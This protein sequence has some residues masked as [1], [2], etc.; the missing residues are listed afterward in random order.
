[1]DL[2]HDIRIIATRFN[3]GQPEVIDT[4][5]WLTLTELNEQTNGLVLAGFKSVKFFVL[6]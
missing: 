1:M 2:K 4:I 3:D 5:C 6:D